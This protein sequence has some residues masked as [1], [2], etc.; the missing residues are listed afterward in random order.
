ME[1]VEFVPLWT[2]SQTERL[3]SMQGRR[4]TGGRKIQRPRRQGGGIH[5]ST[6][7]IGVGVDLGQCHASLG[8]DLADLCKQLFCFLLRLDGIKNIVNE[9]EV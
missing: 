1:K 2:V 7:E 9:G 6:N 5:P 3:Q 8:N 4:Q